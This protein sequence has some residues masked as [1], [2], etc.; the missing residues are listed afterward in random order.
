MHDRVDAAHG[1]AKRGR[2]REI[3]ERDL[4]PHPLRS[5][6][7]GVAHEAANGLAVPEQARK[8]RAPH[9]SR[10]AGQQDHARK[11]AERAGG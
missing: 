3:A 9:E 7:P 5:Q 4:H 10:G 11:L 8:K 2:V 1:V 6:S